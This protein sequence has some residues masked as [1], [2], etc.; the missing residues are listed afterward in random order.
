MAAEIMFFLYMVW[1]VFGDLY[2]HLHA[3]KLSVTSV[4]EATLE[5]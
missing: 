3:A 2:W 4:G 1:I 5:A